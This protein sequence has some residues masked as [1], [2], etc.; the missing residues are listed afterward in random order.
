MNDKGVCSARGEAHR[1][2]AMLALALVLLTGAGCTQPSAEGP[3]TLR[4][5]IIPKALHIPVFEYAP[6]R[7]GA[8]GGAARRHRGALARAG[9]HR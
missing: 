2:G 3:H 1:A 9:E 7:R 6:H 8:R 5:A 4:F